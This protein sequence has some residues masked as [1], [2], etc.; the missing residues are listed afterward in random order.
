MPLLPSGAATDRSLTSQGELGRRARIGATWCVND[1]AAIPGGWRNYGESVFVAAL[2]MFVVSCQQPPPPPLPPLT[3]YLQTERWSVFQPAAAGLSPLSF[4]WR[5]V[6][7]MISGK[8]VQ[9]T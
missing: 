8:M 9:C 3:L 4:P 7:V 2:T 5:C 6:S 1:F